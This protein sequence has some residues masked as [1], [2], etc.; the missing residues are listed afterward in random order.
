MRKISRLHG[1]GWRKLMVALR[2]K[3][4][5]TYIFTDGSAEDATC[6]GGAGVYTT[7]HLIHFCPNHESLRKQIW[8]D[9]TPMSQKLYGSLEDLQGIATL[10]VKSGETI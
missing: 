5:C 1:N 4:T 3:E 10:V 8:P 9:P 2:P 6:N 7:E